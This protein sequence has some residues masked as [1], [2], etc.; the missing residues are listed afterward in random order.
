MGQDLIQNQFE[1]LKKVHKSLI[2][3][4]INDDKYSHNISGLL[5]FNYSDNE[6]PIKDAF[7]ILIKMPKDYP[8]LLPVVI[9]NGG[10]IPKIDKYHIN[11][12]TDKSFCLAS[13]RQQ[14]ELYSK[15]P[16]LLGFVE[17]LVIPFLYSFRCYVKYKVRPFGELSH[18]SLGILEDYKITLNLKSKKE[19]LDFI[20]YL[21]VLFKNPDKRFKIKTRSRCHCG[22]KKRFNKCHIK[23]DEIIKY[24]DYEK[25][26][27][28]YD[29]ISQ[30]K[31]N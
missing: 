22:S 30:L 18:G 8:Q 26:K 16:S 20:V 7:S 5:S 1:E 31:E 28:D 25:L 21:A 9:E 6:Y 4:D 12:G 17:K 14:Q 19:V 23:Y 15:Y 13:N 24:Y 11:P 2:L 27:K 29:A 10:R 3:E